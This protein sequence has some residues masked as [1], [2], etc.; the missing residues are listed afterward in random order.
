MAEQSKDATFTAANVKEVSGLSYRQLNEWDRRGALPDSRDNATSWR[1][2]SPKSLFILLVCAEIRSRFGVP[3]EQLKWLQEFMTKEE[4]DHFSAAV[5]LMSH[6]LNVL[7]LTD[8]K[9]TFQMAADVDIGD[10]LYLGYTRHEKPESFVL[11]KVNPLV[12]RILGCFTPPV[13]LKI[14][15]EI[16]HLILGAERDGRLH[17]SDERELM[18][19]L[20]SGEYSKVVVKLS[21]G[22]IV[23]VDGESEHAFLTDDQLADLLRERDFQTLTVT[24]QDGKVV[25]LARSSPNLVA[26][27]RKRQETT[28]RRAPE[29][30]K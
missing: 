6:G 29:N 30:R 16:Y 7:L 5:R 14:K 24:K 8:F 21:N 26:G 15:K 25:R 22:Q 4:A 17:T 23:R 13:E 2:F 1:K 19:V 20:R 3:L 11:L 28:E 27:K 10:L 9:A 12:N 18:Q